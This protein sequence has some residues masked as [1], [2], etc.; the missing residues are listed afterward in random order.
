[1]VWLAMHHQI[2]VEEEDN[3]KISINTEKKEDWKVFEN[4]SLY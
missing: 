4:E 2:D 3:I 1:M